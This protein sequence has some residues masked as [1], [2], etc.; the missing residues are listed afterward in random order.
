MTSGFSIKQDSNGRME[1]PKTVPSCVERYVDE[2]DRIRKE[3]LFADINNDEKADLVAISLFGYDDSHYKTKVNMV[4]Y[5]DYDAD[6]YADKAEYY[7]SGELGMMF[8]YYEEK[9]NE[10]DK[11]KAELRKDM[12][13]RE[14]LRKGNDIDMSDLYKAY[15][16]N[17]E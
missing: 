11:A 12:S 13:W 10:I 16:A 6:G 1:V 5:I 2:K 7:A 3:A 4:R 17:F 15:G 8:K 9:F 14:K